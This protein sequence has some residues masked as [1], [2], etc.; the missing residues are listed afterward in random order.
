MDGGWLGGDDVCD[1]AVCAAGKCRAPHQEH[2]QETE[3]DDLEGEM[4]EEEVAAEEG[5]VALWVEE[6]AGE[7]ELKMIER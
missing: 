5:S 1:A 7:A 2:D 3:R 6:K 4:Q